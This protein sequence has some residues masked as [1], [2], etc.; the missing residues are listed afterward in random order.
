MQIQIEPPVGPLIECWS[1]CQ[2]IARAISSA[3]EKPI[4]GSDCITCLVNSDPLLH[5]S[6]RGVPRLRRSSSGTRK[7]SHAPS[8]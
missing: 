2:A 1:F 5:N 7:T 8:R 3:D 4:E 6:A